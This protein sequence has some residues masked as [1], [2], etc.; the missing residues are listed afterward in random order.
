[1][2]PHKQRIKTWL[3]ANGVDTSIVPYDS[4]IYVHDDRIWY[5]ETRWQ[6]FCLPE[7]RTTKWVFH[8]VRI[9]DI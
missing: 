6:G 7:A 5:E 1:M 4:E 9:E 3:E 2:P 8:S